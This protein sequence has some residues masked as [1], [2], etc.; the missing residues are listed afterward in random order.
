MLNSSFQQVGGEFL[1]KHYPHK[2]IYLP[3][4]TWANH[5]KI[6][7][8]AGLEVRK[9]RYYLPRTRLLDFEVGPFDSGRW[10]VTE[11]C[12]STEVVH[13][14]SQRV[15]SIQDASALVS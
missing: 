5:N 13:S 8:L 11:V 4:P 1:A 2:I 12:S 9:Y 15:S 7:P 6:F 10:V 14:T 3:N